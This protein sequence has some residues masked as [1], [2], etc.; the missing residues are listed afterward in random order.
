[1]TATQ[2]TPAPS[3]P[4]SSLSAV[5]RLLRTDPVIATLLGAADATVAVAEPAQAVVAAALA[6]FTERTPLLVVTATGLDAERLGDDLAC[7]LAAERGGPGG[8]DVVGAL[9]GPV[10]VLPAWETLPFERVSPEIETMGRRLAVLHALGGAPD[11]TLPA[12]PRVIVAA[13]ARPAPA[14]GAAGR[15]RAGRDPPGRPRRR[16]DAPARA[17]GQ[18]LPARAPGGAPRRVRRARRDRRRLPVH[19]RG[20]RAHRP[21]GGRGRPPHR[22]LGQRPAVVARPGRRR[23]LRLPRAGRHARPAGGGGVARRAAS[24]GGV[25]VGPAGGRRA[26][27]RH[28]VVAALPGARRAPPARPAPARRPGGPGRAPADPRPRGAAARR[29]GRAGRDARR[30]LGGQ[31]G[32]GGQLPPAPPSLRPVA[33]R[34]PGRRRGPAAGPRGA[35]HRRAHRAALRPGGGGPGPAGGRGDPPGRRGL[36]GHAV[37][38]HGPGCRTAV[39][40]PGRRR[41]ARPGGGGGAGRTGCHR[42]GGTHHQRLHP[43][44]RQGGGPLGDRRHGPPDAAPAGPPAG[45]GGRRVLRR[46]RGGELRRP[47]PARRGPLRGCD[48]AHDGRHD[49]RLSH[50]AVPG[51]RPPVPAGGADRGDHPVFGRRV[52]DA[53]EDGR[54]GLAADPCPGKGGG[55]R[56][57]G[58]AGRAL[59]P[60]P[61]GRGTCLRARHAVAGGDG[62]RVRFRRDGGPAAGDRRRQARHGGAATHGPPGLR[63][64]RLRQD[65]GRPTRRLQ[66]RAGRHAGRGAGS[67][68]AAG[69]PARADV[70][71]PLRA[72]PG[73]RR[74]AEPFP[75]PGAATCRRAGAGRRVRRR[76]DRHAPP[77]GTGR[78]IQRAGVAGRRRGAA[79][80]GD[81]QGG[82]EAHGRRGRRPD[83]HR[84]PD[85]PH[86]RDG[87]DRHPGPVDGQ[88]AAGRPPPDPHLRRRAGPVGGERGAATRAA[89][90]GPGVLR[91]QPG[92]GHRPGGP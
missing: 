25:G 50:P 34:L 23:P 55:R 92:L 4:G 8:A 7:L 83:A 91:P 71:R 58:R 75:L 57:G 65:R 42:R 53:L 86:P 76:R 40:G 45:Q 1:M 89:A 22:V 85:P 24:L 74:V 48:D 88:H 80:R 68:D 73:A 18:G 69:E 36:R 56:G 12:L 32:G 2:P 14:P 72:V 43:P 47:S 52:P 49:P 5:P 84:E 81:A 64:R 11:G 67:D 15:F 19:R 35:V 17:G 21:V 26:V 6:A 27:R 28:G 9:T 54:S 59:P 38:R 77:P 46:P 41:R 20:A 78:P 61:G 10:T 3:R 33:A 37:R 60:A 82:R 13:G 51:L 63:R 87:T 70:R 30:H 79:L 66:G 31:G 29:G 44:R 39:R 90:R 62:V 16:R